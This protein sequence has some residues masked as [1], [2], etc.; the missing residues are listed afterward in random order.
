MK[1]SEIYG[2]PF[3]SIKLEFRGEVLQLEKVLLDTGSAS[4]LLNADAVREVGMVPEEDDLVDI[5]RGVGGIEYVYTKSLDSITVDGTT[6]ND[7]Q[8]EI[9]NMDYGL[10][11]DGI[12]GFNFMKQTGVVINAN[13]MELSIDKP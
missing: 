1:I 12:L 11:I 4:T 2:L 10:E 5:I 8:V 7:F 6:I 9:G 3:I 13:L